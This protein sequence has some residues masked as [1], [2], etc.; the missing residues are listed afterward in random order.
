MLQ[1]VEKI[2]QVIR[3]MLGKEKVKDALGVD[4]A[5]SDR[6][7]QAIELW[8]KMYENKPPWVKKNVLSC[9]CRIPSSHRRYSQVL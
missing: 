2:R 1:I 3:K 5:I 7:G 8:A 4:V 9:G 6:M